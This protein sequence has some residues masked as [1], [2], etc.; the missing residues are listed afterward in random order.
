LKA[1]SVEDGTA[2]YGR[3]LTLILSDP[4]QAALNS[5]TA[6]TKDQS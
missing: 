5:Y 4:F 1:N 6:K 2:S 3:A